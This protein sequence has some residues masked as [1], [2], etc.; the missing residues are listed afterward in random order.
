MEIGANAT[1]RPFL[2]EKQPRY[3]VQNSLDKPQ[4]QGRFQ[5]VW[6]SE[7]LLPPLGFE[8]HTVQPVA[9]FCTD[10]KIPAPASDISAEF[11]CLFLCS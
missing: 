2:P 6:R 11:R 3:P 4:G 7:S 9:K 10:Y 1:P 8:I 5:Q